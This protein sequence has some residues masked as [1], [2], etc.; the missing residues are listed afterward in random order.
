VKPIDILLVEDNRANQMIF[1]DILEMEGYRVKCVNNGEDAVA[2][3]R[4]LEPTLILMDIQ[5]PGMDGLTATRILREDRKMRNVPIIALTSYAMPGDREK[6]LVAGCSGY[7]TKPIRVKEFRK[8]IR[9][10]LGDLDEP[11]QP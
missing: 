3:A 10:V 8:E 2:A 11:K 4:E 1:R 9:D 5:L 6:F 7:I